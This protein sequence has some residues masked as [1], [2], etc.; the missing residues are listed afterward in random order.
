MSCRS[1]VIAAI[2]ACYAAANRYE[3]GNLA[4]QNNE[5]ALIFA[6]KACALGL[7]KGCVKQGYYLLKGTA[8][9]PNPA[10][11][12]QLFQSAQAGSR[13]AVTL[14]AVFAEGRVEQNT[15]TAMRLLGQ[16][17]DRQLAISCGAVA[18]IARGQKNPELAM[19]Y[20]K[21]R[22]SGR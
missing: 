6:T 10:A 7:A 9:N 18:T 5:K 21:K 22:L 16:S 20:A 17:C 14:L 15:D 13:W 4:I 8:T 19:T 2:Q 12:R 1:V 3:D 11:A